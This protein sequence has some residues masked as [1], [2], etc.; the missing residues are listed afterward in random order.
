MLIELAIGDAYGA[1][2]E[3]ADR[4]FV[5]AHNDLTGYLQHPGHD[6]IR[7]GDYTDDTQMTLAIAESIV[8]GEPWTPEHL[9]DRFVAVFHRDPRDGYAGRFRDFLDTVHTGA[10][11]LERIIPASDKSGAAMRAAPVGLLPDIAEVLAR[12]EIQA[13]ITHDTADGIESAQAAALA[14][15]YCRRHLGP[16]AEIRSWMGR[17]LGSRWATPWRGKVGSKGWMSVRAALTAL[18]TGQSLTEILRTSI[19]FTGD[20]DTVATI[21]LAAASHSSDVRQNLPAAL[22]SGLENGPFGR[23]YLYDLDQRLHAA[24]G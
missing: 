14:V 20:V 7:P 6:T 23:D 18:S 12:T 15:H 5:V 22:L 2:F 4:G 13:R 9:A 11:F 17:Q 24:V 3:Y 1:G 16:T 21:A 19:A 10:E 8:S